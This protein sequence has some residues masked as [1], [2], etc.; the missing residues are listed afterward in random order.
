LGGASWRIAL[1][2]VDTFKAR[3]I[4]LAL[5]PVRPRRRGERRSLRTFLSLPAVASLRPGSLAFN[6]DTPRRLSTPLLTPFN[7]TPT[8]VALYGTPLIKD[9]APG[10]GRQR[11]GAAEG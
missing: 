8:F 10:P 3:P 11:V 6:P 1:T 5:V 4:S 7:S 2:P 9:D